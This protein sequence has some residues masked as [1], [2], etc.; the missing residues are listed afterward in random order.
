M[1]LAVSTG[2]LWDRGLWLRL[3]LRN[4]RGDFRVGPSPP[5]VFETAHTKR[6]LVPT[7]IRRVTRCLLGAVV[8]WALKPYYSGSG[9]LG[10]PGSRARVGG[11]RGRT[12]GEPAGRCGKAR[13]VLNRSRTTDAGTVSTG[14][15]RAAIRPV[16]CLALPALSEPR[17]CL[18]GEAALCCEPVMG[19]AP[20]G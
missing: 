14:L 6:L 4:F 20:D 17:R 11:D 12:P 18:P 10:F 1:R 13:R 19:Q 16:P 15:L 5:P 9:R 8:P 3:F 2:V 7:G